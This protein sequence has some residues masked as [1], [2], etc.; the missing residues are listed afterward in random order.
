MLRMLQDLS[1]REHEAVTLQGNTH[2]ATQDT[3][4]H[5]A[6]DVRHTGRGR[7]ANI[8][9]LNKQKHHRITTSKTTGGETDV[10]KSETVNTMLQKKRR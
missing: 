4:P 8:V 10:W 2:G 9:E 7:V 1:Y 5:Y 6:A 3:A